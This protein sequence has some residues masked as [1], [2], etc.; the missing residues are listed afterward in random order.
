[1][2]ATQKRNVIIGVAGGLLVVGVLWLMI[3]GCDKGLRDVTAESADAREAMQVIEA[4]AENPKSVADHMAS[5]AASGVHEMV[6]EVAERM[7]ESESIQFGS[8]GWWDG[9]MR[10]QVSWPRPE[11]EPLTRTFFLQKEG[12]RLCIRGLQL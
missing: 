1:M 4:I 9:Y 8:A 6:T 7:A 10:V 11:G 5:D 12:G 3:G 2:D